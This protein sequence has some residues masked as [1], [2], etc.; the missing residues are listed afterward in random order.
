ILFFSTVVRSQTLTESEPVVKSPGESH[1]LTCTWIRQAEGK[2][3]EWVSHISAP[4][5][6]TKYYS[7]SVKNRFTISR[8]NDVDQV[9]LH[10]N[11]TAPT[12]FPV[13]QCGS[14]TGNQITVGCLAHDFIPKSTFQ[15]TDDSG[16]SLPS[17]QYST[18]VNDNKFTGLS[19]ARVSKS[20]WGSRKSFNCTS[21]IQSYPNT[22]VYLLQLNSAVTLALN[23]PSPKELFNN[24]Q[25][26]LDCIVSGQ[27]SSVVNDMR[28]TW[29][30]NE[31]NVSDAITSTPNSRNGQHSKISTLTRSLSEWQTVNKVRCSAMRDNMTPVIQDLTVHKGDWKKTKVTVHVLPEE[32]IS[33]GN[34]VTLVCLVSSLEQQ[35]YYIAWSEYI[36]QKTGNYVDGINFPP[37]KT[38]QG[39]SVTSVYYTTKDKWNNHMYTC[40]VWPAGSNS[41]MNPQA[42]SKAQGN[43]LELSGGEYNIHDAVEEDEF[44]SLWSTA[45]SFIFLFIASLFYSMIISLVKVNKQTCTL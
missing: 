10:M 23:Q 39:Y 19:L 9:Y 12:L 27:D 15:W 42:V 2:G 13:V 5:G 21:L 37:Q 31:H 1:K 36:G 25:A 6:S 24:N 43:S 28:I 34:E 4:S 26:K 44:S 14:G 18:S 17:V 40:N 7:T 16:T 3:L 8:D 11:R 32:E 35:D 20:D 22:A 33:K 29:Q 30:I 45:A 38:Q 41:S